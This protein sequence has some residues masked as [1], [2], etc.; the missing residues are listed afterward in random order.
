M[1]G[2]ADLILEVG[3]NTKGLDFGAEFSE[4]CTIVI[5]TITPG[6]SGAETR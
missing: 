3:V 2:C 1:K 4:G 6:E 5:Q